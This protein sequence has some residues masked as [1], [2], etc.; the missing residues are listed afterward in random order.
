MAWNIDAD[1][2]KLGENL[3]NIRTDRGLSLD[4]VAKAI[5]LSPSLLQQL[6]EGLYPECKLDT[7]FDLIAYYGISGEEI[8]GKSGK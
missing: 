1:L 8:F 3:R 6:E 4:T 7:I 2:K 5:N